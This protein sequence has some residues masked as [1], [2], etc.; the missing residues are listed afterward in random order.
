MGSAPEVPP[1]SVCTRD[2]VLADVVTEL[3]ELRGDAATTPDRVLPRNALDQFDDLGRG[4]RT[5]S[6]PRLVRPDLA[7]PR[8][9]HPQTE[10]GG[11]WTSPAERWGGFAWIP[12]S[13][14]L[15]R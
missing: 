8:R 12:D 10:A 11:T 2:R 15:S 14:A 5:T 9:C 13:A 1:A 3:S 7:N 4:R 6:R